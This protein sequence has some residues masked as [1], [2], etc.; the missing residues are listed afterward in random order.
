MRTLPEALEEL[1]KPATNRKGTLTC[2]RLSLVLTVGIGRP[3]PE[4]LSCNMD[5]IP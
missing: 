1:T 4:Q 3:S 2:G 5:S